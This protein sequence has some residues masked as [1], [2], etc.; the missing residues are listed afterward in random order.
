MAALGLWLFALGVSD[1]GFG[2]LASLRNSLRVVLAV[3]VAA[4]AAGAGAIAVSFH[5]PSVLALVV[6]AA[7]TA[8]SWQGIR[9][10]GARTTPKRAVTALAAL[11]VCG[12]AT[13]LAVGVWPDP[14][15]GVAGRFLRVT[16]FPVVARMTPGKLVLMIGV[17]AFLV[18]TANVVVR[19]V[20]I[21]TG[22][23]VNRAGARLRGGRILGPIERL[24]IFGFGVAGNLAGAA[25]V[26]SA[27][28][29]LRFPEIS[30][31]SSAPRSSAA[32]SQS[33]PPD[34]ISEYVLIGSLVSWLL[35]LVPVILVA[36]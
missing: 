32:D 22:V 20:L 2:L 34:E 15:S 29:I 23:S 1:V 33:L 18:E 3:A 11:A 6:W 10:D 31:S 27:K 4:T 16:P 25:L 12:L 26:A 5:L 35:A 17:L 21:G 24:L 28:S 30:R 7:L 14:A 13:F 19:L 8:A 9:G 36:G